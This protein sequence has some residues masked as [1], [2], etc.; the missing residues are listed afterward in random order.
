MDTSGFVISLCISNVIFILVQIAIFVKYNHLNP[1][2][3]ATMVLFCLAIL[4]GSVYLSWWY[5]FETWV[6]VTVVCLVMFALSVVKLDLASS[7]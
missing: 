1:L 6:V 4:A 2:L 5:N 7:R 3:A